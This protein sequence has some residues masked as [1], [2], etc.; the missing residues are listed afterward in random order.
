[1]HESS[2]NTLPIPNQ[3]FVVFEYSFQIDFSFDTTLRHKIL[4]SIKK[5][6]RS[7]KIR[8]KTEQCFVFPYKT[9]IM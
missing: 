6:A 9:F 1:M 2:K 3:S 8:I 5:T 4:Y 7:G